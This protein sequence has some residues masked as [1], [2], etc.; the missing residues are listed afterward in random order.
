MP[1]PLPLERI[2]ADQL[3]TQHPVNH[4]LDD[5]RL[6]RG[7]GDTLGPVVGADL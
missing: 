1:E 4:A 2:R 3:I 5:E 7:E 6:A